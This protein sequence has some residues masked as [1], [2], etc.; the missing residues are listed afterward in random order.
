LTL[1]FRKYE[2]EDMKGIVALYNES[3]QSYRTIDE[4]KWMYL[5]MPGFDPSGILVAEEQ[6]LHQI[7]GS[8]VVCR[9]AVSINGSKHIIGI[10]DDVDTSH[11]WRGKGIATKLMRMAINMSQKQGYSAL[12][13]YAN[14][15]GK[16]AGIYRRLGFMDAKYFYYNGKTARV[17]YLARKLPFPLNLAS[18]IALL[19]S[20]VNRNRCVTLKKD[21]KV[22][23]LEC[24][25][26]NQLSSYLQAL[27]SSLMNTPLFYPYSKERITWMI[28][29][30]PKSLAPTARFIVE[31]GRI[32]C[33]ANASI[34]KMRFFG[35]T[36]NSWVISDIFA[37]P[38]LQSPE[39][40]AYLHCLIDRLAKDGEER[41]CAFQMAPLS[42]HDDEMRK[43]LRPSGFFRL[44]PTTFM[45]LPLQRNFSLPSKEV[46]W[47][48]WKQH[49]IGVP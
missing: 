35:R 9:H 30:A 23:Q 20:G 32:L 40:E 14:P 15:S 1:I 10:I 4:W 22:Q 42:Q 31:S 12:F 48:F 11:K 27:N 36:F 47:Y 5:Q 29:E 45:C 17:G 38:D 8:L 16:A 3:F 18:P 13:L 25:N 6:E 41:G 43:S 24:G 46:P 34:Y 28:C 21:A 37:S 44:I 2:S 39:R 49:M 33:G 19:I 26:G 7:V